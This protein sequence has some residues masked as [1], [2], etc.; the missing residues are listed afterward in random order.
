MS[1]KESES[2]KRKNLT[3]NLEVDITNLKRKS[4]NSNNINNN[5]NYIN[6]NT[7]LLPLNKK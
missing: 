3:N 2:L 4:I 7:K 5:N 6:N 1:F